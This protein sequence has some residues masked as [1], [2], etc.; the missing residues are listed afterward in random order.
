MDTPQLTELQ[1]AILEVEEM[2]LPRRDAMRLT[3]QKVGYFVG[4]QRYLDE[5]ARALKVLEERPNAV[6]DSQRRV[7]GPPVRPRSSTHQIGSTGG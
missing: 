3:T 1:I 6:G 5:L 2:G 4:Q 7:P